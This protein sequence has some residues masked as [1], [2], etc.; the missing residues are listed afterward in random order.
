MPPESGETVFVQPYNETK[1]LPRALLSAGTSVHL[2]DKEDGVPALGGTD[3]L[4]RGV[5]RRE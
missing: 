4:G 3:S 1:G 2:K 5:G